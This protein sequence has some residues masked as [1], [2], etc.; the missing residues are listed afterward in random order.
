MRSKYFWKKLKSSFERKFI[1]PHCI[2]ISTSYLL[3]SG[4]SSRFPEPI[5]FS[6]F[7]GGKRRDSILN[8]TK[9]VSQMTW[10]TSQPY[11]SSMF[12]M[13]MMMKKWFQEE[14]S[15]IMMIIFYYYFTI[16]IYI[17]LVDSFLVTKR[18]S[19]NY[20]CSPKC[21]I[22]LTTSSIFFGKVQF[23]FLSKLQKS[24]KSWFRTWN[25]FF[26]GNFQNSFASGELLISFL[27]TWHI[28]QKISYSIRSKWRDCHCKL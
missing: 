28:G 11:T 1:R 19:P 5:H 23:R 4:N 26:F 8:R 21:L 2:Q 13:L 7:L 15:V 22:S 12:W 27:S 9:S 18:I 24:C 3:S 6:D 10:H 17:L 14:S 20:C 25:S 16:N